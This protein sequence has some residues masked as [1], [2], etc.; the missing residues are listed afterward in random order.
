MKILI[1]FVIL[2]TLATPSFSTTKQ[3]PVEQCQEIYDG[4][5]FLLTMADERWDDLRANG[6]DKQ[7]AGELTWAMNLV[8]NHTAVFES[9]CKDVKE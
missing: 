9:F 4:I 6:G 1:G 7:A 3:M 2:T 5:Q 8:G